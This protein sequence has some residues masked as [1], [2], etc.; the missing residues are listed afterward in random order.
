MN[1]PNGRRAK[2]T[3]FYFE[4]FFYIYSLPKYYFK[5]I[6]YGN[7]VALI[8]Q[9]LINEP[10]NP[11]YILMKKKS[12]QNSLATP[13]KESPKRKRP[14]P[15]KA[16][17]SATEKLTNPPPLDLPLAEKWYHFKEV[18]TMLNL[19]RPVINGFIKSGLLI[20]HKWGGTLRINKAYLDWMVESGKRVFSFLA[21]ILTLGSDS[22]VGM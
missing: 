12:K 16:D 17:G 6:F 22:L 1:L 8:S 11:K 2:K 9:Q 13:K 19:T 21:A 5:I 18:M 15:K 3:F 7:Q 10:I 4:N 20:T 14:S